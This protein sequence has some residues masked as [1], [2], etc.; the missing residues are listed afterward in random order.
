MVIVEDD[1]ALAH[2]QAELLAGHDVRVVT[3][4]FAE[5]FEDGPWAGVDVAVVDL[6]LPGVR[7][8]DLLDYLAAHHPT[9]RRVVSTAMPLYELGKIIPK[10]DYVLLKPFDVDRL[11]AAIEDR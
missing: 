8:E 10:A 5:L 4:N 9:V 1:V 11:Q 2:L 7:G 3:D 6:M